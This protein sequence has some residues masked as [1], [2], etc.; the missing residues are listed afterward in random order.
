MV[1][2]EWRGGVEGVSIW[3]EAAGDDSPAAEDIWI[4]A[5]HLRLAQLS[6]GGMV[7]CDVS[8][9]FLAA[10]ALQGKGLS[11]VSMAVQLW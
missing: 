8:L 9:G 7:K 10:G 1:P 6:W 2:C 3:E 11:I 4:S 5:Q